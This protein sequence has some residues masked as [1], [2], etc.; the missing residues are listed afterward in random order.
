MLL[1]SAPRRA[2]EKEAEA[3]AIGSVNTLYNEAVAAS[4]SGSIERLD[5]ARNKLQQLDLLPNTSKELKARIAAGL[6]NIDQ[7]RGATKANRQRNDIT[8]VG[9]IDKILA[10][11]NGAGSWV[12]ASP[13]DQAKVD[14]VNKALSQRRDAL[15]QDSQVE[16]A[17]MQNDVAKAQANTLKEVEAAKQFTNANL[18]AYTAA[19]KDITKPE[20]LDNLVAKASPEMQATAQKMASNARANAKAAY[21]LEREVEKNNPSPNLK[22]ALNRA[23]TLSEA[24]QTKL[25]PLIENLEAAASMKKND[26]TWVTGGVEEYKRALKNYNTAVSQASGLELNQEINEEFNNKKAFDDKMYN[27]RMDAKKGRMSWINSRAK[28]IA[29]VNNRDNIIQDDLD[30]ARIDRMQKEADD[31]ALAEREAKVRHGLA[32]REDIKMEEG[33]NSVLE[34]RTEGY[35]DEAIKDNLLKLDF[36]EK[37]VDSLLSVPREAPESTSEELFLEAQGQPGLFSR[38]LDSLSEKEWVSSTPLGV[39]NAVQAIRRNAKSSGKVSKDQAGIKVLLKYSK[40]ELEGFGVNEHLIDI[41][42]GMR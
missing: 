4:E 42:E 7:L 28:Q 2:R 14:E 26:G 22:S 38:M 21:D 35:S 9:N 40:G 29:E 6:A 32:S 36:T 31:V 41:I 19:A 27:A 23:S 1:G 8:T 11:Q 30:Q 12:G 13:R 33:A 20:I 16:T 10:Q 17:V 34:A 37:E 15:M 5:K 25:K 18:Q 24:S 3:D 39:Q